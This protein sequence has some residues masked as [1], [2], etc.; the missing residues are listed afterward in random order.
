MTGQ[1]YRIRI[2][3]HLDERWMPWFDDMSIQQD[4]NGETLLTGF[5]PDQ[6]ALYGMLMKLRDLGLALVSVEPAENSLGVIMK[7]EGL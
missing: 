7:E 3:S 5:V 4:A 1:I 2:R 6:A